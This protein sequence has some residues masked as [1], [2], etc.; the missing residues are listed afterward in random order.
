MSEAPIPGEIEAY[1]DGALDIGRKF[2]VETYLS[3][4][5]DLAARVMGDLGSTSALRLLLERA[6]EPKDAMITQATQLDTGIAAA[7]WRLKR[8]AIAGISGI[9][10]AAAATFL[11]LNSSPPNYVDYAVSSHRI[12]AIRASMQSQVETPL[13]DAREIALSTQIAIDRKSVV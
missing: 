6:D 1:V 2:V 4:H 9:A 8:R 7:P 13:Y 10:V 3:Q 5:P 12:A 11:F